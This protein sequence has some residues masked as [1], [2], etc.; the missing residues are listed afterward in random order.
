MDPR[1]QT[2]SDYPVT[3]EVMMF[4]NSI[5]SNNFNAFELHSVTK[6]NSLYFMLQYVYQKFSFGESLK[7]KANKFQFFSTKL[8]AAYRD[9]IYHTAIHAAD[10][11]QN[12]Y[13]YI[14]GANGQDILKTTTF[15]LASLFIASAAHDVDHPGNN[16]LYETKTRSK[17]AILY[18]DQAVLENH[19]AA[20]FYF[21]IE[22][23]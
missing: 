11:L 22:D 18:N 3:K 10:V 4:E 5:N 6:K 9:N 16:N 14:V 23:E 1:T 15:D 12:V 13:F 21:M 19:H 2:L 17:L 8:E 7:I 20:T